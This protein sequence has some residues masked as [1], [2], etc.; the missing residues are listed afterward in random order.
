MNPDQRRAYGRGWDRGYWTATI[1]LLGFLAVRD[2]FGWL[3][4]RKGKR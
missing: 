4:Q 1:G 2:F 3:R